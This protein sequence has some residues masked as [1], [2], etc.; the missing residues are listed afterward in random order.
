MFLSFTRPRAELTR[1]YLPSKSN[2]TGV[3]C[4]PP[5][6]ITVTR[7]ANAFFVV[8]RSR[9]AAGSCLGSRCAGARW[10]RQAVELGRRDGRGGHSRQRRVRAT[11]PEGRPDESLGR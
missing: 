5:F 9:N 1:M 8:T 10:H 7:L 6:G 2:Q 4:G 3:T 11:R